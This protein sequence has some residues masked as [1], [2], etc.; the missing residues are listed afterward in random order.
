MYKVFFW[1]FTENEILITTF[2][3]SK[4]NTTSTKT[5]IEFTNEKDKNRKYKTFYD[6]NIRNG[7]K[8]ITFTNDIKI[9]INTALK[10]ISHE[11]IKE[12]ERNE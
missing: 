8:D 3:V 1:I 11:G 7:F 4:T 12:G 9:I 2:L 10:V 5:S 6:K